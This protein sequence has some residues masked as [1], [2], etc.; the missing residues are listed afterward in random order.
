M[1]D[2]TLQPI[3]A[4]VFSDL[5]QQVETAPLAGSVYTRRRDGIG[6]IYAKLPVGR[7]RVDR[8]VGKAGDPAAEAEVQ[9]L[10]LGADLAKKR[11]DIVSLLKRDRLAGPDRILGAALDAIAFAGL[12]KQGAVLVGTAAYMLF[13]PLV[14]RRL[15]AATLMTGDLDLATARLALAADPPEAMEK[16][17]SRADPSFTGIPQL[18]RGAPSSRFRNDSGYLVDLLTPIL[19]RTDRNPMPL[20]A[21]EAG[22]APLHYLDWLI[23]DPVPTVALWGSGIA[24]NVPQPARF[25]V[26]KLILAQRRDPAN[27]HKRLKDLEQARAL[28]EALS[29]HDRF[30]LEDSLADAS[31]KGRSG[32]ADPIRRSLTELGR[33]DL[34]ADLAG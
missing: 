23:A 15:P 5:V 8:F 3:I 29:D 33:D 1:R 27:R 11:R 21:L 10:R 34:G 32:W 30:A 16:I 2:A 28:I 22:A 9:S 18:D 4:T 31:T 24:V 19:R 25:A 12:F 6:Y 26:H 20:A 17:L 14:G 13:E 7:D